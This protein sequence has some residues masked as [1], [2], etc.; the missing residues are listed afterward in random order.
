MKKVLSLVLV[1]SALVS[2]L[3]AKQE[4][5]TELKNNGATTAK[6]YCAKGLYVSYWAIGGP[7]S[8]EKIL[9]LIDTTEINSVVI[10]IKSEFGYIAYKGDVPLA[11]ELGAYTRRTIRDIDSLMYEL[12][13]RG[14]Y[15]IARIVVFKDDL[16]A[17]KH[18][19]YSIF[20]KKG[21]YVSDREKLAWTNPFV[22]KVHDYNIEIAKDAILKGFDEVNF[23]YIRFPASTSLVFNVENNETTRV[24]AITSFL[25]KANKALKPLNAQI[26]IDT[27]GYTCWNEGDTGIGQD[28]EELVKYADIISPM[29]Y[30]SGFQYGIPNYKN[31]VQNS[32][33]TINH[34]LEKAYKRTNIDKARFRPWLQ[35]FR[36][37]G[38]D[39]RKFNG[40]EIRTQIDAAEDFGSCGWLLWHPSSYFIA[41]GLMPE[42]TTS[43]AQKEKKMELNQILP[44][45]KKQ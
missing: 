19:E 33:E 13:K 16:L 18:P 27:Y 30:P 23:D 28:L 1:L 10:D 26:S 25:K 34:S 14:V 8:R 7:K 2:F 21:Q 42:K 20:T 31:P 12:K 36:D 15:T 17:K 3:Y 35:A 39:K 22:E 32:Y 41:D 38:F 9:N 43:V 11:K 44:L 5:P 45:T 40:K 29:L 37:Y 4:S 24:N 6:P